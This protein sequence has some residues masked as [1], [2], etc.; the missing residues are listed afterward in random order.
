[1]NKGLVGENDDQNKKDNLPLK[2]GNNV[3]KFF[4][5][6]NFIRTKL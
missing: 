5:V 6:F 2:S 3:I 1:M 4:T